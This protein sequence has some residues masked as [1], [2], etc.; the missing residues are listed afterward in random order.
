[1]YTMKEAGT[2]DKISVLHFRSPRRQYSPYVGLTAARYS[3]SGRPTV[4]EVRHF[5]RALNLMT[6]RL[7]TEVGVEE[8]VVVVTRFEMWSSQRWG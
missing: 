6:T 5:D 2:E 1:M 4:E 3:C 8:E 7:W